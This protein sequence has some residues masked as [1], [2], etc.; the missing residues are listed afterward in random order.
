MAA[1][2]AT[3]T[4]DLDV[5]GGQVSDPGGVLAIDGAEPASCDG[6]RSLGHGFRVDRYGPEGPLSD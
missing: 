4:D 6:K 5:L 2:G 3:R 1:S